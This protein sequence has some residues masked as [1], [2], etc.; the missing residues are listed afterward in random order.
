[1]TPIALCSH[2]PGLVY[3]GEGV[4]SGGVTRTRAVTHGLGP[5]WRGA[6][7]GS[8]SRHGARAAR[9]NLVI[10]RAGPRHIRVAIMRPPD[11]GPS[12][13][14]HGG[15]VTG[16][17]ACLHRGHIHIVIGDVSRLD[18]VVIIVVASARVVVIVIV[19]DHFKVSAHPA[20]S[21]PILHLGM[22]R[23]RASSP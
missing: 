4:S 21:S 13:G 14:H 20:P 10:A 11:P 17:G 16:C 2:G 23:T 9:V 15:S 1:M 5:R 12:E 19:V 7:D 18:A 6:A 3:R 22:S 8:R